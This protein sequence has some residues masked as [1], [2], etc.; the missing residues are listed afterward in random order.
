M[1]KLVKTVDRK[2]LNYAFL[3]SLNGILKL[4]KRELELLTK[5]VE[6]DM[7]HDFEEDGSKDVISTINRKKIHNEMGLAYD[8]LSRYLKGFKKKGLLIKNNTNDGWIVNPIL[9]PEIVKDRVQIT[10]I[11]RTNG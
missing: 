2:D 11:I 5:L 9:I 6:I 1:N 10:I 4:A 7:T 3:N 8:N